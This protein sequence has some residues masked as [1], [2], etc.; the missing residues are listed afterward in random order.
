MVMNKQKHVFGVV[1]R[2]EENK[3]YT[4][5][6]TKTANVTVNNN[7]REI[8]VDV[9]FSNMLGETNQTAYPGHL[10]AQTRAF[11]LLA[12]DEI[13]AE[14]SR[15]ISEEKRLEE[16][17]Q[18]F[19]WAID[20]GDSEVKE[21]LYNE[22]NRAKIAEEVL[23]QNIQDLTK[24]VDT[25]KAVAKSDLVDYSK[26][27][28]AQIHCVSTDL[29]ATDTDLQEQITT[30]RRYTDSSD[31][32]LEDSINYIKRNYADKPYVYEQLI[33]FNK[34]HKQIADSVDLVT[35]VVTIN[36]ISQ[37]AQSNVIYLVKEIVEYEEIYNQ[38][39][40]IDSTLTFIGSSKIDLSDYATKDYVD[41][42]ISTIDLSDYATQEYVDEQIDN[43][44]KVDLSPYAKLEDIPD[45]SSFI[46]EIPSEY[47]TESELD[48]KRF[49]TE[50]AAQS[51]YATKV[52]V[53][54]EL[55]KIG[56]LSKE[57][58]DG[59]DLA[60]NKIIVRGE[61]LVPKD[62]QIYLV[63]QEGTGAYDQYTLLDDKLTFI[64]S[65]DIHLTGYAT[66]EY[67]DEQ[68]VLTKSYFKNILDN[69][70]FIDGGSSSSLIT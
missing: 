9:D 38:Y 40:L 60:N 41:T 25:N 39:T 29:S 3:D 53:Q 49:L 2:V 47:I 37:P 46:D 7:T 4:G 26:T 70:E 63:K 15:A 51:D 19:E 23:D 10:G 56:T 16:A 30:L 17:I 43:I 11:V 48:E 22:I 21:K 24:I 36:G 69:L 1:E 67:V 5:I 28:D 44:P 61:T 59:V 42:Q 65:T 62:N 52:Y 58:V 33:E 50:S 54:T 6:K 45:V 13:S 32:Q 31:K 34:L 18:D 35:G 66:Q 64:G 55:S 27:V 8:G 12:R 68:I 20:V 14:T 57:V